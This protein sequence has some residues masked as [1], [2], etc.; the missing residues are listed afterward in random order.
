MCHESIAVDPD[1]FSHDEDWGA[2]PDVMTPRI[3]VRDGDDMLIIID[4]LRM[5]MEA[6]IHENGMAA[7]LPGAD[8]YALSMDL[9]TQTRNI[10]TLIDLMG[11]TSLPDSSGTL[12]DGST[13]TDDSTKG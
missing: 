7:R 3:F 6:R 9:I 8:Q 1:K 4:A 5:W 12:D 2:T 13:T 10:C 11:E